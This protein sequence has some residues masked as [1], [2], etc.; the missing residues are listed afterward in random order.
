MV[1]RQSNIQVCT[2]RQQLESPPQTSRHQSLPG[3]HRHTGCSSDTAAWRQCSAPGLLMTPLQLAPLPENQHHHRC[4]DGHTLP[5]DGLLL[6]RYEMIP[7]VAM[8]WTRAEP[9]AVIEMIS[10]DCSYWGQLRPCTLAKPPTHTTMDPT[11]YQMC[12]GMHMAATRCTSR[13]DDTCFCAP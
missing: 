5:D 6:C 4:H 1:L 9:K 2:V 3:R 13:M 10:L 8:Q 11:L 7:C 12:A